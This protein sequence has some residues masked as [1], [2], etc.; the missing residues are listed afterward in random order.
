[1]ALNSFEK[2]CVTGPIVVF[3]SPETHNTNAALLLFLF[4]SYSK[5]FTA[6]H[7]D[8]LSKLSNAISS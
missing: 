2:F 7:I 6:S 1:M 3:T 8:T 5:S 4:L